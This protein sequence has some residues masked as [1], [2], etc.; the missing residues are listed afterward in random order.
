MAIRWVVSPIV[1]A[2]ETDPETGDSYQFPAPKVATLIEPG[3]GKPYQHS[4]IQGPAGQWALSFVRAQDF[5]TINLDTDCENVL[6]LGADYEDADSLLGQTP[7]QR[8]WTVARTNL[9]ITRLANRGVNTTGLDR[10]TA[11]AVFLRRLGRR[12]DPNFE[13]LHIGSRP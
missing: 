3:R 13:P 2:T 5:S 4:S 12:F 10:D 6:Q 7:R 9:L 11:F 8:G 1:M